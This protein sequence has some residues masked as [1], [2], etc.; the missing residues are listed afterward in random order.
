MKLPPA[1][2][3]KA[4]FILN[5]YA[6][7]PPVKM[8]I[9]RQ[10]QRRRDE[11]ACYKSLSVDESGTLI[12]QNLDRYDI[13]VAA[14]GDGTVHSVASQLAGTVK[15]LAVLPTGSGNGFARELGFRPNLKNLIAD[16]N[17]KEYVNID[18]ININDN[19]CLNVAGV[20]LDSI[21][22]HSFDKFGTRGFWSYAILAMISFFRLK[23]IRVKLLCQDDI[24]FDDD[25]FVLTVAN[26]RQFG[27]RAYIAPDASPNDGLLNITILK[28]FPKILF[29]MF[30]LM[31]FTKRL[32]SSKYFMHLKT[33]RDVVIKTDENRFHIDGE[34]VLMPEDITV[35]IKKNALRILKTRYYRQYGSYSQKE[36]DNQNI[37][38]QEP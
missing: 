35:R 7:I 38:N 33:D 5:P 2:K 23:P 36:S 29:P 12:K 4:L 32:N 22:A 17:K 25:V 8:I 27:Y 13:F 21:V 19:L 18:V 26:T 24:L 16:I 34:P 20:G 14:G 10:L 6:G 30:I 1:D 37:K 31:L 3:S 11:L 9:N 15:I 28:P